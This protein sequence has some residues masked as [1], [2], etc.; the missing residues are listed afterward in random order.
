MSLKTKI[1][2]GYFAVL[3]IFVIFSTVVIVTILDVRQDTNGLREDI[4]P[5]NLIVAGAKYT[6]ALEGL[7]IMDYSWSGKEE[8]WQQAMA[9]RQGTGEQLSKSDLK[10]QTL[11]ERAPE[12]SKME[13]EADNLYGVFAQTVGLLPGLLSESKERFANFQASYAEF[14]KLLD[15][16]TASLAKRQDGVSTLADN[17]SN[18]REVIRQINTATLL[19]R[20]SS[21]FY[22]NA[23]IGLYLNDPSLFDNAI[24]DLGSL[25]KTATDFAGSITDSLA[26]AEIAKII[27]SIS[28]CQASALALKDNLARSLQN[29]V[30]RGKARDDILSAIDKISLILNDIAYK[31]TDETIQSTNRAWLSLLVGIGVSFVLALAIALISATTLSKTLLEII[32]Q[33]TS[34]SDEVEKAAT[35]LSDASQAVA[36]G[37][38]QNA[39]SLEETSAAI[40][41]LSSMTARNS[42]NAIEAQKLILEAR[43]SVVNS[44]EAMDKV[45]KA[46]EQIAFSGNE[47]SKII[48]T[49]DEIAFQ[50]NLLA[51]NA[52]VEAARAGESGAGFAVVADEVRNL[53]IRSADAAKSTANLIDKTIENIGTGSNLVKRTYDAFETLVADVKKVSEII[54]GVTAASSEQSQGISQITTAIHEMDQVTQKNADI[55]EQTA[56]AAN[57][58]TAE[59]KHLESNASRLFSLVKGTSGDKANDSEKHRRRGQ[60]LKLLPPSLGY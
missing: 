32:E 55:S 21:Y 10:V 2:A 33:L 9:L 51:L 5:N 45:I 1:I 17:Q 52:A 57:S 39:A 34:G 7:K 58:L 28:A 19:Y 50:T 38:S 8:L 24:T 48:K 12:L 53:A 49:I 46:M 43:D 4:L 60:T 27:D 35:K 56:E 22:E 36:S 30:D 29:R 54:E 47:I 41:E 3:L 18:L 40:E 59:A 44:E 14:S 31:F 23:L 20:Q 25:L 26:K 37:T 6:V 13:A 11:Q 16:F 15:N 42:E